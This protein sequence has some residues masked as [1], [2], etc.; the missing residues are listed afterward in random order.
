MK[1]KKNQV[2]LKIKSPRYDENATMKMRWESL[3]MKWI[4]CQIRTWLG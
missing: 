2:M 3:L 4:C 1:D